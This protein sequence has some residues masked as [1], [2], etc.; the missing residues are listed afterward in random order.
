MGMMGA[1]ALNPPNRSRDLGKKCRSG[2]N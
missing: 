2:W 1:R